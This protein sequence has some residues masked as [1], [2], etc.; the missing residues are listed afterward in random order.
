MSF[1]TA[2]S[3][4]LQS[5]LTSIAVFT[6]IQ[7]LLSTIVAVA[8][9]LPAAFFTANRDFPLKRFLLSLSAVPLCIPSL[10]I[11]LGYVSFFGMSGTLNRFLMSM[12]GSKTPPLTFLYSFWGII[13]CHGFYNFPLVMSTVGS[14]WERL[15]QS[16]SQVARLLGANSFKIFRTITIYQLL[17]ALVSACIPVFLYCFFSFMIVLLFGSIG[18]TTLEVEIFQLARVNLNFSSA[19]RLATLETLI[20]LSFVF[21]YTFLEQRYRALKGLSFNL[22]KS[23]K[24][25]LNSKE[26][27]IA[28]AFFLTVAVFFLCPLFSILINGF[29][30]KQAGVKFTLTNFVYIFKSATFWKAVRWTVITSTLTGIFCA[31]TAFIYAIVLRLVDR[32]GRLFIFRVIPIIPM[33]VSSVVTGLILTAFVKRGNFFI[34]VLAQTA[35]TWPIA[36]RQIYSDLAKLQNSTEDAAKILSKKQTDLIF[37]IYL[38]V[39]K[40]ALFRSAGFCFALSAGDATLPLVLSIPQF[41]T[42]SLYIYR[43]AGTYKFHQAC[44]TGSVLAAICAT[45]FNLSRKKER[46]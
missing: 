44:A 21:I 9:G 4:V 25:Q 35:L 8:I 7:A 30:T 13:V 46:N 10:L 33:A 17:P 16:E 36:F 38:P 29:M 6:V 42:L 27:L 37:K 19:F 34:L 14:T 15:S 5:S 2:I 24:E 39:C 45:V 12:T 11:A 32:D 1:F 22:E 26:V 41:D 20:A 3:A 40:K 31:L 28:L 43:L 23:K 18:T